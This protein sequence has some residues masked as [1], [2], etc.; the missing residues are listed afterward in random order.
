MKLATSGKSTA[1]AQGL[2]HAGR[3]ELMLRLLSGLSLL[4]R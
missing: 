2:V 4:L 1:S 3:L